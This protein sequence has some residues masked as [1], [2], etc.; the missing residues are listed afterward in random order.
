M[1]R[2]SLGAWLLAGIFFAGCDCGTR[3]QKIDP[4]VGLVDEVLD[5]GMVAVGDTVSLSLDVSALTAAELSLTASIEEAD[6]PFAIDGDVPA[7]VSGNDSVTIRV[8]FTPPAVETYAATLVIVTNDPDRA[9]ARQRVVLAGTGKS[10]QLAVTPAQLSLSAIACPASA[11]SPRCSDEASII[12]ENVGEVRLRLDKVEVIAS[13]A[14]PVPAGLGLAKLVN[15]S[16]LDPGQTLE[17]PVRWKPTPAVVP[18]PAAVDFNAVLSIVN[19]DPAQL[20]VEIPIVAHGEPNQAPSA[21]ARIS[22]VTR[23]AYT[24]ANGQVRQTTACVPP[25]EYGCVALADKACQS[26]AECGGGSCRSNKCSVSDACLADD[27]APAEA[28]VRPGMTVTL[29]ASTACTVDP[30]GDLL[31]YAWS[32]VSK[33]DESRARPTPDQKAETS[34]EID[35]VG[36][37][38]AGLVVRDSLLLSG[39]AKIKLNAIPR[40]DISLQ[41]AWQDAAGVDLDL[42]LLADA[43]PSVVSDARLFC[44]QDCF[45]FNPSPSWFDVTSPLDDPRLLRDDQGT[46]AQLESL[47]LEAAPAGSRY[48]VVVHEYAKG[49]GSSAVTP[50]LTVRLKGTESGPFTPTVPLSGAEDVWVAARIEFPAD[51]SAPTV[52]ALQQHLVPTDDPNPGPGEYTRFQ[53]AVGSCQ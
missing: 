19:N 48:R 20:K 40:D 8:T 10:P 18:G 25:S 1:R 31:A 30:E 23:R 34:L 37:Y 14:G 3:V 52:T 24:V 50:N 4:A 51:G 49:S 41:L 13:G 15:T 12:V 35:A 33:P 28:P 47:S 39:S 45:F 32:L 5:F 36:T 26:D 9:K 44:V 6:A 29:S 22:K 46:A 38:E 11:N 16:S 42:H 27:C 43:G 17:V 21:C 7:I 53:N 2:S